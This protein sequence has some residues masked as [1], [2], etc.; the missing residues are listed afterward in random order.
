MAVRP[1]RSAFKLQ[2]IRLL[3]ANGNTLTAF[4]LD[5]N[6]L[7][8]DYT[9]QFNIP[10]SA[11]FVEVKGAKGRESFQRIQAAPI[12]PTQ[13]RLNF[14]SGDKAVDELTIGDS[15]RVSFAVKNEG[16][17]E[18]FQLN[19]QDSQGLVSSYDPKVCSNATVM[20]I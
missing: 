20:Q 15:L 1:T 18:Q 8:D 4:P 7:T 11:F 2:Q 12:I 17:R 13:V 10:N 19:V 9:G 3:G 6:S 14:F 16:Q 5:Y